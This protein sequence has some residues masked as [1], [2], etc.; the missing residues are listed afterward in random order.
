MARIPGRSNAP[1][2]DRVVPNTDET[3]RASAGA[4]ATATGHVVTTPDPTAGDGTHFSR[5]SAARAPILES[6][7]TPVDKAAAAEMALLDKVIHARK[8]DPKSY[9]PGENP[10]S[11][12]YAV[13]NLRSRSIIE[14]IFEAMEAGVEVKVL[15]EGKQIAPDRPWNKVDDLFQDAGLEVVFDDR[16][17]TMAEKEAASLVGIMSNHLMHLKT[18][19]FRYLDPETGDKRS[20][21]LS[22]SMNPGDGSTTN[23]ENI[24]LIRDERVV[25]LYEK[26]FQ[27]VLAHRRTE[28]QFDS[29]A[30]INVLFTPCKSGPRPIEKLFEW[31]DAEKEMIVLSVFDV[32]NIVDPASRKTLVEKLA[33][34]KARGV[35]VFAI[36]DRKKS[37]GRNAAGDRVMMYGHY[38]S[39]YWLDEDLEKEGIPVYE[40]SNERTQFSAMHP[41]AAVFGLSNMKVM[42]GAGNWTRAGIGSGNKRGRN[43]ESF[44]FVDSGKLDNNRT[45]RRYLAN[46]LYLLRKYDDQNTEHD[47]AEK[48]IARLQKMDD[49]PEV[50]LDPATLV[51]G[52]LDADVFL[53]G[54]HP[55]LKGRNGEPGLRVSASPG[56]L[57]ARLSPTIKLPFGTEITYSLE[58]EDGSP[59]DPS[60]HEK[61][62]VI[63]PRGDRALMPGESGGVHG[64]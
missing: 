22:G 63:V 32:K 42:T 17:A 38:A 45:G 33:E 43:E 41:K 21:A 29:D 48:L 64:S 9:A 28:N 7:F 35:E 25:S 14:K 26:K 3:A 24:N 19:I 59:L 12:H 37:D 58:R 13:Y 56:P 16:Q 55:A 1:H 8:Q 10:Y 30:G 44:I 39:N 54:A 2:V 23:D 27:D 5:S 20:M 57:G 47:P 49:W 11:I 62:L 51:P 4:N 50:S 18:R 61:R 53:V 6:Y 60:V 36:T 52:H 40:F 31:I 46:C 34:A 15:I